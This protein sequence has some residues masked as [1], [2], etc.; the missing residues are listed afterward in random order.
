MIYYVI[1]IM[2]FNLCIFDRGDGTV[3]SYDGEGIYIYI[4]I[5]YYYYNY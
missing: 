2:L 1:S 4:Y 5:Y 3:V